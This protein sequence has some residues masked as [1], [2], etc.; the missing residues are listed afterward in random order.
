MTPTPQDERK[1][2]RA[3]IAHQWADYLRRA[4]ADEKLA[5]IDLVKRSNG[6]IGTG[7]VTH[8][9]N[10]D[11][12]AS[13]EAALLISELLHRPAAEVLRA[14]GHDTIAARFATTE[15]TGP[16]LAWA[17][18]LSL[19]LEHAGITADEFAARA[20]VPTTTVDRWLAGQS[21]PHVPEDAIDIAHLLKG[22][23]VAAVAAAG[24]PKT[25]NKLDEQTKEVERARAAKDHPLV[26]D[27]L[28]APDLTQGDKDEYIADLQ[29]RQEEEVFIFQR[30]IA[31]TTRI[32]RA[33]KRAREAGAAGDQAQ[34]G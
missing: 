6:A 31:E 20:E 3:Q 1:A 12:S 29:R 8:W 34:A 23:V 25:A 9:T 33:A 16:Y 4:L 21:A 22:N 10:G 13:I 5:P 2:R 27:I 26:G 14:A 18:W 30:R 15:A 11:N 24:H 28:A 7:H 17:R 32:R 19:A